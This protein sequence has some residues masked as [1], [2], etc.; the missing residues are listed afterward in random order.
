MQKSKYDDLNFF[1]QYK[2]MAR[3]QEGLKGAGEWHEF[4]KMLPDFKNKK[5]LD[6]GC[7]FGWHCRYAVEQGASEV[8]GVELSEKMLE[9]ARRMTSTDKIQYI[10]MPI[11][12]IDFKE[13][14]FNCVVSSL[15]F[16][17]IESF[18]SVCEKVNKCLV[19]G[20][21]FIF[22]VEHPV[23][24]AQGRQDWVYDQAGERIHW[25]VDNY[26]K[27]GV[28]HSIFL[29]EEVTKYHKT[30]TTYVSGLLNNGF[31]ILGLV[32][33]QPEAHMLEGNKEM[34]DE[35]RRPMMLIIKARKK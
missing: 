16:H 1:N 33:P 28:R 34:Q 18:E 8:I 14:S 12:N 19:K 3:S 32:E 29:G 20:G 2:Q 23:F 5:V 15:V 6:L 7:G 31:E 27:E 24:T 4:K 9:E 30:I 13:E 35:L 21:E 10:K 25:P 17:Y 26:Y 11:E 22:S